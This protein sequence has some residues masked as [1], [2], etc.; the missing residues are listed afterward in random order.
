MNLAFLHELSAH[1]KDALG[2]LILRAKS[3]TTDNDVRRTWILFGDPAMRIA[4]P[5][6]AQNGASK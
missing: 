1:P 4:F 3:G 2:L 6:V 5:G